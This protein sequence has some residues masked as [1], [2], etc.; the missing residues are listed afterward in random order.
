MESRHPTY[1][2]ASH[3]L[4]NL[5]SRRLHNLR[6]LRWFEVDSGRYF[7][8][9]DVRI[10]LLL[11]TPSIHFSHLYA[12]IESLQYHSKRSS[13][14]QPLSHPS[15]QS[16]DRA[17]PS[18]QIPISR[19]RCQAKNLNVFRCGPVTCPHDCDGRRGKRYQESLLALP[20]RGMGNW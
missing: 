16:F 5:C 20:R 6:H 11:L 7:L 3:S 10:S 9:D 4:V 13:S 17:S 12:D 19:L 2:L 15:P 1:F 14:H 8:D 18:I